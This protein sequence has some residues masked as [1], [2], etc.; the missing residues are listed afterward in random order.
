MV[1]MLY[2]QG[3]LFYLLILLLHLFGLLLRFFQ[4]AEHLLRVFNFNQGALVQL[5]D[6]LVV[7]QLYHKELLPGFIQ[8]EDACELQQVRHVSPQNLLLEVVHLCVEPSYYTCEVSG[9]HGIVA[10][11][12][13]GHLVDSSSIGDLVIIVRQEGGPSLIVDV[14]T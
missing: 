1:S 11:K 13:I 3:H 9:V 8:V 12:L 6:L 7:L 5:D 14:L 10:E 4:L 2:L